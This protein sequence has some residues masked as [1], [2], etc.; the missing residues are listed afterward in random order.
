MERRFGYAL[1]WLAISV[2]V[3][4]IA[5]FLFDASFVLT[6]IM[7]GVALTLNGMLAYWEDRGKF[8]D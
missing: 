1:A 2:C 8:N 3:G 5:R 7:A 4:L 6:T